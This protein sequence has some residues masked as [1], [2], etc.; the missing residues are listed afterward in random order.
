MH[1]PNGSVITPDGK[2]LI[3]GE[4]L[5]GTLSAF[6]ISGDGSLANRRVWATTWPRV[7]DGI[8]LDAEG[9]IWIAN[10]MASERVLVAEGGEVLDVID[11]GQ[12]CFA[13]MLGAED[14]RALFMLTARPAMAHEAAASPT[15]KLLMATVDV[16]H[17]GR[18]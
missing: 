9:H 15:G 8:T 5:G 18:P 4:S 10:P 12:P 7:P 11:T 14:G 16:P 3:V 17:A 2:T 1:F 6:D 13:C